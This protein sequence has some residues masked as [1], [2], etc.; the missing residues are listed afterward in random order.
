[1]ANFESGVSSYIR[2]KAMVEVFFPV[3]A[4]GCADI[5]C[6]QCYYFRDHSNRCG[7]N[8]EICQ[9]PSKYVGDSCPLNPVETES[10]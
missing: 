2:A 10:E 6:R 7:L 5:S 4:K 8:G 3:D 1:M 9:Y